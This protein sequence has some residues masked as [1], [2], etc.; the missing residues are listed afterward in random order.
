MRGILGVL[1]VGLMAGCGGVEGA[2]GPWT[3]SADGVAGEVEAMATCADCHNLYVRCM[4][5]AT[6][7]EAKANC[8]AGR[9]DCEATFC[10]DP[11]VRADVLS[12]EM[13]Q[14]SASAL[15]SYWE[16]AYRTT[17]YSDATYTT[18]VGY[19][20]PTCGLH[21]VQYHLVGTYSR[22]GIDEL[23]GYCTEGGMEPL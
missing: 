17:L 4:S 20:Y 10:P 3:P 23:V 16:A 5:R 18:E 22:Y 12:A 6:T 14:A 19:I 21:Y 13:P 1:L 11:P 8:E 15:P 7:P 9:M 2:S